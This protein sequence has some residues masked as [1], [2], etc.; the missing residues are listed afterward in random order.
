MATLLSHPA[1]LKALTGESVPLWN[2]CVL[3]CASVD[4]ELYHEALGFAIEPRSIPIPSFHIVGVED[5]AR[6]K[7]ETA[8]ELF[9]YKR[10]KH[11][12]RSTV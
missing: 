4:L 12:V 7:S 2:C 10:E 8:L 11:I 6:S 9:S 3:A 5:V 1:V